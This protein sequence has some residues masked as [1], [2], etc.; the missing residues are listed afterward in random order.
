MTSSTLRISRF[1]PVRGLAT[2]LIVLAL[3]TCVFSARRE[4]LIDTWRP[5]NYTVRIH[6]NEDLTEITNA[7]AEVS[8]IILKDNVSEIDFDFG[9]LPITSVTLD[10]QVVPY[11]R[12]DARLNVKPIK[13][14]DRNSRVV[15]VVSYHGKPADGL[16]MSV[17]KAGRRSAIG[18]NWPN[19]V[20]HWIPALD[21]PSAKATVRFIVTAPARTEVIANGRLDVVE[22]V[23][24]TTKTW[25]FTQSVPIP[26]Y[27]MIIAVGEFAQVTPPEQDVTPLAY[28]VPIPEKEIALR[29]FAPAYP[30]LKYFTETVADYPYEKLALIVGSTRFGG[31]ENSTAIVFSSTLF[32]PRPYAPTSRT[33]QIR[34]G[35]VSLVAHEIAHQWFGDSVTQ[36]TWSDLWLSEGFATYFAALFLR[37]TDGE[38][39][40]KDYM[41]RAKATYLGNALGTRTPLHDTETEDLMRLLNPNNYQKGAWVLHM[42]RAELGDTHFFNGI[43]LY[44]AQ[45]K[46]GT[47]SSEDLRR[48]LEKVSG[49][50]L[51][52]F[53]SSWIYG[54][55]HPRYS[56]SWHWNNRTRKLRLDLRQ[57]QNQPAFRNDIP[58]TI[59]INRGTHVV[60]LKPVGKETKQD[61]RLSAA[62][63]GVQIDPDNLILKEVVEAK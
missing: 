14:L 39:A 28:Y 63:T 4:R 10:N 55:G 50:D 3:A 38:Q 37:K 54:A 6:L 43:R 44:Y 36:S 34:E 24:T 46:N 8:L 59:T 60:T 13:P 33:F 53:F 19:R 16:I 42:L 58:I 45:H 29:G 25:S 51:K 49:Q 30:S 32:D 48:A 31:M 20:H 56:L 12:T 61:V 57:I 5:L 15:V 2:T 22:T 17:D 18:D 1:A 40:F 26:P 52:P 9:A 62:P 23:G 7:R 47:A 35:I 41:A 21:H 27:C 11:E